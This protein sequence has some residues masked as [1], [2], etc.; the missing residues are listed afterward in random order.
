MG[1]TAVI[2]LAALMSLAACVGI[3]EAGARGDGS[4]DAVE[5]TRATFGAA[6][7]AD[8]SYDALEQQRA[9]L[10]L[11]GSEDDHHSPAADPHARSLE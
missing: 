1:K 9:V 6:L 3:T 8:A 7:A 11:G 2:A 4:I 5:R 10:V